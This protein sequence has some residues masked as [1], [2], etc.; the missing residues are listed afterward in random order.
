MKVYTYWETLPGK[1]VSTYLKLCIANLKLT[2]GDD[3]LL[4]NPSE[5]QNLGIDLPD[6]NWNFGGNRTNP[7]VIAYREVVAKS[8]YLRMAINAK[9][10]GFWLDT[11]TLV[12]ED[13]RADLLGRQKSSDSLLW[14]TES[15]FGARQGNA[16]LAEAAENMSSMEQQIW[17]NPGR[18]RQIIELESGKVENLPYSLVGPGYEPAYRAATAGVVFEDVMPDQF[19][20]NPGQKILTIYN[21]ELSKIDKCKDATVDE[22][23]QAPMLL[24]RIMLQ[25]EPDVRAWKDA[26]RWVEE[27]VAQQSARVR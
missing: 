8:D 27:A 4:L 10:G 23:L 13:F 1:T 16:I 14:Y 24:S 20:L 22:F 3:F 17:N 12:L 2:F 18:I 15:F 9:F 19:L 7:D 5:V 11:D 25:I 26:V 6:A 21:S